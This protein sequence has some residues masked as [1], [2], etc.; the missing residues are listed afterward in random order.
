[1]ESRHVVTKN[2]PTFQN[3]GILDVKLLL[4]TTLFSGCLFSVLC[5]NTHA[6]D[7]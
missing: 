3:R 7:P 1:M 4:L 5:I 2:L 6:L